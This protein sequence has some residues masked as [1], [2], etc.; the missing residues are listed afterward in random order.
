MNQY[1]HYQEESFGMPGRIF[2]PCV[3]NEKLKNRPV[4]Y[5][6]HG[7]GGV[8]EWFDFSRGNMIQNLE[9][10]VNQYQLSPMVVVFPSVDVSSA[11]SKSVPFYQFSDKVPELIAYVNSTYQDFVRTGQ[12]NT[13]IAGFSMGGAAALYYAQQHPDLFYHVCAC[14]PA[15]ALYSAWLKDKELTLPVLS[16]SCNLIGR[17]ETEDTSFIKTAT[18]S[19]TELK[20]EGVPIFQNGTVVIEECGHDFSAFNPVLEKFIAQDIFKEVLILGAN[21]ETVSLIEKAKEM[22]IYT[23]VTDY[24][25]NAYAK[26]YADQAVDIDAVDVDALEAF[27]K[28]EC[29]GGVV[30]GVAEALLPTYSKLCERLHF[31]HYSTEEKFQV[32]ARKDLF[33]QKCRE[34]HVPTIRE[35]T[36]DQPDEIRFPVIVKPVDSCSSK[37]IRI[38]HN[39]DE[40]REAISY[41]LSFSRSGKYLI[42]EYMTGDEV[43]SYYVM[44][45]GNPIFVGMCD[46]YTYQDKSELVQLPTSYIYPSKYID[47]YMESV[48]SAIK[49]MI[50]GLGLENGSI[51]FQCFVDNEGT[52]RVYE[53]GYRLNGAQ[54]HLLI[55]KVSGIDAKALYIHLALTGK[56]ADCDLEPYA[57]PKPEQIMCKLSPL[58]RIGKI[59]QIKGLED[60]AAM[61]EVVSV[62]PSYRD[63]DEVTG[64]GT[65]KQIICRFYIISQNKEDLISAIQ[66]IYDKLEVLDTNGE[67]MLIGQF[68]TDII[69]EGY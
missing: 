47:S 2:F 53:P 10:W 42:E 33:K 15:P 57:N 18:R 51:F 7:I 19:V 58:V 64:E 16:G 39:W 11:D 60:I 20:N 4:L 6:F 59:D 36:I 56:V 62:N 41:A 35:Y 17:G 5:L 45:D 65:L 22:G 63:G 43:I 61:P 29:I 37:G 54:E 8:Q 68:D 21:P 67:N 66:Q 13:A 12:K 49:D 30:V 14:S 69:K 32:M 52:V 27:V 31:P 1:I 26:R 3:E 48:D 55:S 24:D 34:F 40:L 23:Y 46:R 44:Q 28:Q 9:S 25:H 50:R 38:C